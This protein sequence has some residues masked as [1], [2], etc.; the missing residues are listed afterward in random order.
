MNAIPKPA[1]DLLQQT[2][3]LSESVTRPIPGSRKI[4]VE[5]SRP[6]L[7]V[8]MREIAQTQTPT[9]FGGETNPPIT[10]Y[11]PS[12]PY[13]DPDARI[14]L[15]VGLPALRAK[16]IEERGD[17]ELLPQLSSAFG[18]GREHDPKL[19]G[20]RFP[21]RTLPRCA[22]KHSNCTKPCLSTPCGASECCRSYQVIDGI[23]V[24]MRGSSC[25][26]CIW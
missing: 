26:S 16:W 2:G 10:V 7:R 4:F 18:R 24:A 8:A 21:S 12:G 20:V 5:G 11:D 13:T 17:T 15:S 9:L 25:A 3:Q 19:A 23:A 1:A 6:D 14:D 22:M